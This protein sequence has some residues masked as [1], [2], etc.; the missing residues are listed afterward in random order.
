MCPCVELAGH[1][2]SSPLMVYEATHR[3][4]VGVG[5]SP[6][7]QVGFV[8]YR[9]T[10]KYALSARLPARG[11]VRERLEILSNTM[12]SSGWSDSPCSAFGGA[13]GWTAPAPPGG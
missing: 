1:G 13:V 2:D 7:T 5:V 3:I 4:T 10:E 8:Y 12:Y 6:N 11:D 9:A